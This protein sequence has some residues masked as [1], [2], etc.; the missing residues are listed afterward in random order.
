MSNSD[1]NNSVTAPRKNS[2]N[3]YDSGSFGSG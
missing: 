3:L 1:L 2:K